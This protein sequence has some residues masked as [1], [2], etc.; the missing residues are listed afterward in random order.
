MREGVLF[1]KRGLQA[2]ILASTHLRL[3]RSSRLLAR[4]AHEVLFAPAHRGRCICEGL[5]ASAQAFAKS[6]G[7]PFLP[8][9]SATGS[10]QS[11]E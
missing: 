11:I 10:S 7:S 3:R 4:L 2:R 5:L 8:A 9:P 1:G 6:S